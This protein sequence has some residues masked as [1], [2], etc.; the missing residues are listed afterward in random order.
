MPQPRVVLISLAVLATA[1][2]QP[3]Q[4]VGVDVFS[5]DTL[6]ARFVVN[7]T[8]TLA[9]G[10]RA[11]NFYMRKDKSLVLETPASLIIQKGAGTA[12]ISTLDSMRRVAVQ[13]T[14]VP[15]DSADMLGVI[16]RSVEM[17]HATEQEKRV[18]LK[19]LS[20]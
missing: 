9:I 13:P 1:C 5:T 15:P 3:K 16:G 12:T 6:P 10:L 14:G 11:N 8:G 4:E 18:R 2:N 7:V 17:L 19:L 20:R